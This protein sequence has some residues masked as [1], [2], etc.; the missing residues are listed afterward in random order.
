[1]CSSSSKSSRSLKPSSTTGFE[2][3]F[4]SKS[5]VSGRNLID[6]SLTSSGRHYGIPKRADL[7]RDTNLSMTQISTSASHNSRI[8]QMPLYQSKPP[9]S[10]YHQRTRRSSSSYLKQ[11]ESKY[12]KSQGTHQN[13]PEIH[14]EAG[15]TKHRLSNRKG[16]TL[17]SKYLTGKGKKVAVQTE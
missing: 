9:I 17:L 10:S 2:K 1:M 14:D 12:K 4:T 16:G 5:V 13:R 6:F 7:D 15:L 8:L 3:L 11:L